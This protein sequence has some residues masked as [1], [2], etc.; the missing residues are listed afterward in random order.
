VNQ[1]EN[2]VRQII[3]FAGVGVVGT[4]GHYLVLIGLV[5][6]LHTGP[7]VGS[8]T[9]FAGGAI[10]NYYLNRSYTFDSSVPHIVGLPRFFCIA[11]V[12]MII[13]ISIVAV[14]ISK[15]Q[16]HY[17]IAQI[18]ATMLVLVWGFLGNKFWTFD[19]NRMRKKTGAD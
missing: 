18:I 17:L 7:L 1:L 9:G 14:A 15:L 3:R 11:S 10:I 16:M 4:A 8:G 2:I 5:E 12:G 19:D 13:N 6:A